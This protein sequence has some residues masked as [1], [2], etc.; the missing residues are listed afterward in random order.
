M[1]TDI[2]GLIM[3]TV[4]TADIPANCEVCKREGGREGGRTIQSET[5]RQ[6][7]GGDLAWFGVC[8]C[9]VVIGMMPARAGV[10]S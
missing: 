5:N 8:V 10:A 2:D 1:H 6:R 7:H 3:V 9:H 4:A